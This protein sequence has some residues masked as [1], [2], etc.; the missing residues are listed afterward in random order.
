MAID[1]TRTGVSGPLNFDTFGCDTF[2]TNPDTPDR[3][4]PD[5]TQSRDFFGSGAVVTPEG[6]EVR[7]WGFRKIGEDSP[8]PPEAPFVGVSDAAQP[9]PS[10]LIRVRRGQV[11]HTNA[12]VGTGSHTLHL[13][14][15]E[16]T[17]FNDGVGHTSF[18]VTGDYTYQ[19]QPHHSGTYFYHCHKNTV[20]HFEM[21]MYGG[22]I[23]DPPS[24]PGRLFEGGP[25]YHREVLWVA[26]DLEPRWREIGHSDGLCGED[27]GL[28][29]F[30]PEVF[31]VS[32][33]AAA[34]D[35][36]V[37]RDPA[38]AV[39]MR[40]N[41]RLLIRCINA[42]YCTLQVT[43]GAPGSDMKFV[44]HEVDGRALGGEPRGAAPWSRPFRVPAGRAFHLSCAQRLAMRATAGPDSVGSHRVRFEF[45]NWMTDELLGVA[46]TTITVTP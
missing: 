19:W 32:G 29:D 14:G 4:E 5:A 23:V 15:I 38:V 17:T 31:M 35:D 13:H 27:A 16:P 9:T 6:R 18:E 45:L 2:E 37:I 22:L 26:D 42:S 21:G 7:M 44:V 20:L 33:I 25:R 40:Q 12:S 46:E 1:F 3:V 36:P 43:C 11:V 39:T 34:K 30:R 10:A 8:A 41:E 24:G 28:N